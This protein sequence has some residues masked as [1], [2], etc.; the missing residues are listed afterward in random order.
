M[1]SIKYTKKL[2][3]ESYKKNKKSS[4]IAAIC[5]YSL[6]L[7]Q[8][9][10]RNLIIL[11]RSHE[12]TIAIITTIVIFILNAAYSVGFSAYTLE[13]IK[14]DKG[15]IKTFFSSFENIFN[16]FLLRLLKIIFIFLWSLLLIVPGIIAAYRYRMAEYIMAENTGISPLEAI[17]LSKQMMLDK[18]TKLFDLDCSFMGWFLLSFISFGVVGLYSYPYHKLAVTNFFIDVRNEYT[19]KLNF[20]NEWNERNKSK[21]ENTETNDKTYI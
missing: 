1:K 13:I 12:N 5:I 17:R 14:S 7:I 4:I 8:Y 11:F 6:A 15:D 19:E 3:N 21:N 16:V 2:A 20:K 18:K 9:S 10:S